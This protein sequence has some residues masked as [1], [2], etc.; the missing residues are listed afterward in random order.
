MHTTVTA[1]V[2]LLI[3]E[4]HVP[5]A[6]SLK[7][8]RRVVKSIKD[9]LANR[10]NVSIA[11]IAG[12]EEWQRAVLGVAMVGNDRRFIEQNLAGVR[13]WLLQMRDINLAAADLQWL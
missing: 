2:A 11:E 12:L 10:Y 9:K 7:D 8:K 4:I 13:E 5:H 6:A 3:V 1:H